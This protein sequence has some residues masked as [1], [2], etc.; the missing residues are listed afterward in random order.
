MDSDKADIFRATIAKAL[1]IWK[2]EIPDIQPTVPF[3]RTRLKIPNEDDWKIL[4]IM[5]KYLQ[6][7]R[8]DKMVLKMNNITMSDWYS[9]ASFAVNSYKKSHTGGVLTMD[10]VAIQTI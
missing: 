5:I 10:K 7:T 6:E 1:F 2:R 4:L 3:L 8:Y 9:D